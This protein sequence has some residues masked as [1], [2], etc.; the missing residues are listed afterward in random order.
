M[1][2]EPDG[3]VMV[4]VFVNGQGPF[5]FVIDTG[6]NRTA[7]SGDLA[8]ALEVPIVAR[9]EV[10]GV[11]GREYRPVARIAIS[12]GT[13]SP[14]SL[15]ASIVSPGKLRSANRAARGI[16]GQDFLMTLNYTLDY[17][18]QRFLPSL[19][20]VG[21]GSSIELPLEIEEG[22]TLLALPS[23]DGQPPVRMVP[24]SGSTMFVVFDRGGQP[25]FVMESIGGAMDVSTII[26]KQTLPM[27][28]L[29]EVRLRMLTLRDQMA[30]IVQ[31]SNAGPAI[32]ALLPLRIF[33][34]V[35]FDME[36]LRMTVTPR[37]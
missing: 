33:E 12:I 9:T 2:V 34:K 4:P 28:R 22:R 8:H 27:V 35:A 18:H 26:S 20:D 30:A 7:L 21:N 23:H 17:K 19:P 29:R 6:S 24:D 32:D 13:S 1:T 5:P 15:L 31:R 10:I 37:R 14:V 16:I 25:P 36:R 3:I 11:T